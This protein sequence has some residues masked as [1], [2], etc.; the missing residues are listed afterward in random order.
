MDISTLKLPGLRQSSEFNHVI[1]IQGEPNSGKTTAAIGWPSPIVMN[2]DKKLRSGV[3]EIPFWDNG[4]IHSRNNTKPPLYAD[5]KSAILK[6]LRCEEVIKLPPTC[7]LI[8][9]SFT[10]I[11]NA[12]TEF[13]ANNKHAFYTKGDNPEYNGRAMFYAKQDYM[14][15]LFALFKSVPCPV[16]VL[17]HETAARD[18]KGNL[19]NKFRPLVSGG[20]FKDQLEGNLGMML[21]MESRKGRYYLQVKTN[22]NFD[23]MLPDCYKIPA[24]VKE[25]DV[26][27]KSVYEELNKYKT[28]EIPRRP[29]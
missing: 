17:F 22:E 2:F 13:V 14:V 12:W 20:S 21:R 8:V 23:A 5:R 4:W 15:E 27:D 19:N 28:N 7:T 10:M 6:W 11:D 26:T 24:D 29:D 18:N 25:I 9:D 16:I 1:G 3:P